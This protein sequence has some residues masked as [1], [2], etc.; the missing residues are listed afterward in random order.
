MIKKDEIW[1]ITS[2][3]QLYR[4]LQRKR[5][6]QGMDEGDEERKMENIIGLIQAMKCFFV[7]RNTKRRPSANN[8]Y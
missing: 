6:R 5:K 3:E 2:R 8:E 1:E 7:I 4:S